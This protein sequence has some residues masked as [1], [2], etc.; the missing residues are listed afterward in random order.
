MLKTIQRKFIIKKHIRIHTGERPR[1]CKICSKRVKD[2]LGL[3]SRIR[4]NVGERL[5]EC[6]M[7]SKEFR[8]VSNI[9]VHNRPIEKIVE[10]R[11]M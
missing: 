9:N 6:K 3:K 7:C 8:F 5:Y 1:K 4:I 2:K 10:T 11:S